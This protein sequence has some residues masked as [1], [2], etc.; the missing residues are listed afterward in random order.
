MF[1]IR[2]LLGLGVAEDIVT[3][4]RIRLGNGELRLGIEAY[5]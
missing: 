4:Q 2:A 1:E 5:G 3:K